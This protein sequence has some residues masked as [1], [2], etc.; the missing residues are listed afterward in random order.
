MIYCLWISA[1]IP[2]LITAC[3]SAEERRERRERVK[4]RKNEGG[5]AT[6]K[7]HHNNWAL[8]SDME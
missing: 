1:R 6:D 8:S 5:R 4:R 3:K 2:A 7:R